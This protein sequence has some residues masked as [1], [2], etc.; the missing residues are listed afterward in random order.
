M[1][2]P[3]LHRGDGPNDAGVGGGLR[4]RCLVLRGL[5]GR[6]RRLLGKAGEASLYHKSNRIFKG[7][8][9]TFMGVGGAAMGGLGIAAAATV[10]VTIAIEV[11]AAGI[12]GFFGATTTAMI[13]V[14]TAATA[15]AVAAAIAL[16]VVAAGALVGGIVLAVDSA[17]WK[18]RTSFPDPRLN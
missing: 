14:G 10:P 2:P 17:E 11:P 15:G 16:P 6:G 12:M 1:H 18:S 5:R 3:F 7:V 4:R 13:P 8:T 9:G